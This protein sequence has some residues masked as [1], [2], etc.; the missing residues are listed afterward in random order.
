ME[1]LARLDVALEAVRQGQRD[2]EE[3]RVRPVLRGAVASERLEPSGVGQPE[4]REPTEWW[5]PR[6]RKEP[7]ALEAATKRD[8]LRPSGRAEEAALKEGELER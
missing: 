3:R 8:W 2:A 4:G 1:R 5:G 6:R 7:S